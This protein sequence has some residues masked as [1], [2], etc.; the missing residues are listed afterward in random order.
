MS[1]VWEGDGRA[2]RGLW[3]H[4]IRGG[5]RTQGEI[6]EGRRAHEGVFKC[7][8]VDRGS[9]EDFEGV[10]AG[11][12]GVT[13]SRFRILIR[14]CAAKTEEKPAQDNFS[15]RRSYVTMVV[16]AAVALSQGPSTSECPLRVSER[17]S[18]LPSSTVLARLLD[19]LDG[20]VPCASYYSKSSA[21][22]SGGRGLSN[23]NLCFRSGLLFC[24]HR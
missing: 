13:G 3:S 20:M 18:P 4:A 1:R 6:A 16:A 12:L 19:I 9:V 10:C 8:V 11:S 21:L 23:I 15:G 5:L 24:K 17:Q 2:P 22:I 14:S 7:T